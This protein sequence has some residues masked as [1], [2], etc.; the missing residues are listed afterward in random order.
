MR[1]GSVKK[2][3]SLRDKEL[4]YIKI[5]KIF[6]NLESIDIIDLIASKEE[7]FKDKQEVEEILSYINIIF[8]DKVK[9]NPKYVKCM[10]IVEETK[11]RLSKNNNFDMAIDN[12]IMTV[13]EEVNG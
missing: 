9:A 11:D 8:F 2:A 3:L 7:V 10:E 5:N 4:E 13:W 12:F 1:S 6:G